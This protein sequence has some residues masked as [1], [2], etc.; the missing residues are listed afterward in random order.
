MKM[1]GEGTLLKSTMYRKMIQD[2][3]NKYYGF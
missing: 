3:E 1:L 2:I